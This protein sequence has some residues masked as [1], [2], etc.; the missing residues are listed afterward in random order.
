MIKLSVN[1][2]GTITRSAV[3]RTNRDGVKYMSFTLKV[4]IPDRKGLMHPLSISVSRDG[5]EDE[6]AMFT[7]SQRLAV[8]GSLTMRK[9]GDMTYYN[10]KAS[11]VSY[12]CPES[13]SINGEMTFNGR[14]GKNITSR[15][16][17]YGNDYSVFSA[18]SVSSIGDDA[19]F[20]WIRFMLFASSPGEWFAPGCDISA[21]GPFEISVND[22]GLFD[23]TCRIRNI[24]RWER[25]PKT[26]DK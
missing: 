15:Q 3:M 1:V 14:V 9:Q 12:S 24:D 20:I 25:H 5:S 6:L 11:S 19:A 16:D 2:T 23:F 8:A 10:L 26:A 13:D 17:R 4:N 18:F 22:K 7:E 21:T